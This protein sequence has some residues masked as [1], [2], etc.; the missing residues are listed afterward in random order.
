MLAGVYKSMV[1]HSQSIM[2]IGL[3][4]SENRMR[5]HPGEVA[6]DRRPSQEGWWLIERN[7][8]NSAEENSKC[9]LLTIL[10]IT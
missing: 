6:A 9:T 7:P 4:R 8:F 3:G 10:Y 1:G 2:T 5:I